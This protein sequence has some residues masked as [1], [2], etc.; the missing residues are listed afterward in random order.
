LNDKSTQSI[1]AI[2]HYGLQLPSNYGILFDPSNISV[3]EIWRKLK[4]NGQGL[5]A[6]NHK[7][8]F[9]TKQNFSDYFSD[10]RF[11]LEIRN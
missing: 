4:I 7:L 10:L 8:K 3:L 9:S 5:A 2:L 6:T 1:S 11:C